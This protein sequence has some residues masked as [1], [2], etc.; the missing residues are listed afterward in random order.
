MLAATY[1]FTGQVPAAI[2]QTG[3]PT[4]VVFATDLLFLV[5]PL[6]ALASMIKHQ[7]QWANLLAPI[8]LVKCSLYPAV[9]VVAGVTTFLSTGAYDVLTPAYLVLGAGSIWTMLRFRGNNAERQ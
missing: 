5:L 4:G 1:W 6:F 8:I 9:F 3:H 2:L 7:S